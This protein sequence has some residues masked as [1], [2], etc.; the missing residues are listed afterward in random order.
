MVTSKKTYVLNGLLPGQ[1]ID[2]VSPFL[3][4]RFKVAKTNLCRTMKRNEK[5]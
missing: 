5:L 1:K 4:I 3:K 2:S